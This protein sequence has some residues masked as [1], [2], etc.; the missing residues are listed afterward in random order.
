MSST[1]IAAEIEAVECH[2]RDAERKGLEHDVAFRAAHPLL[3]AALARYDRRQRIG[4]DVYGRIERTESDHRP[5]YARFTIQVDVCWLERLYAIY[6]AVTAHTTMWL[7]NYIPR[8]LWLL[9][10]R[11]QLREWREIRRRQMENEEKK[12]NSA[13][14]MLKKAGG[15]GGGVFVGATALTSGLSTGL[16]HLSMDQS[17]V[18]RHKV[19]H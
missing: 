8:D 17:F 4:C 6:D 10:S 11:A 19:A 16:A 15:V 18:D 1:E 9:S 7:H 14:A 12:A 3:L 13:S 2:V 5:V